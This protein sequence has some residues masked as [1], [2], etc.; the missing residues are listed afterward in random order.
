VAD[1]AVARIESVD[2]DATARLQDVEFAIADLPDN[3]LGL[4]VGN[5]IRIDVDAAGYGW[6]VEKY[7]GQRTK[8]K[9]GSATDEAILTIP[10]DPFRIP[11]SVD[12]LTVVMHELGH[13]LGLDH[14]D[15][16][17]MDDTLTTAS[18]TTHRY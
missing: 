14:H 5:T 17:L 3:L 11:N 9:V 4:T 8:D 16:G 10:H 13:V 2:P 1:A 12:L 7:K 15:A 6:F 18:T